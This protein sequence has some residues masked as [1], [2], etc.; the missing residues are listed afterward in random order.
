MT[1]DEVIKTHT[2]LIEVRFYIMVDYGIK[3]PN[4]ITLES[5]LG[6]WVQKL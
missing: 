4:I 1:V 2:R 6:E 3:L 5:K